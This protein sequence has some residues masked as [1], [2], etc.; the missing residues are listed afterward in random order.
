MTVWDDR[1]TSKSD[2][3]SCNPIKSRA[4]GAR[5]LPGRASYPGSQAATGN[6][7]CIKWL[8]G[9]KK[10]NAGFRF[11]HSSARVWPAGLPAARS[12][13]VVVGE[14]YSARG[15]GDMRMSACEPREYGAQ[16]PGL[17]RYPLPLPVQSCVRSSGLTKS[18]S[19]FWCM[20]VLNEW[21]HTEGEH[22]SAEDSF[23][24][25]TFVTAVR[26]EPGMYL[27]SADNRWIR[28]PPVI[29]APTRNPTLNRAGWY[30]FRPEVTRF[31]SGEPRKILRSLNLEIFT[32]P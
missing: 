4:L 17:A 23:S 18:A 22:Q 12:S 28:A 26:G 19:E 25:Q 21:E 11:S 31:S 16:R 30:K 27:S 1:S 6:Q 20:V 8:A 15:L 24:T 3:S 9:F 29:R 2:R 32:S 5:S 7:F 14:L 13:R 10:F